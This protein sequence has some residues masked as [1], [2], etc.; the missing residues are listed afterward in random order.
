MVNNSRTFREAGKALGTQDSPK[1]SNMKG[2][3]KR[4]YRIFAAGV[5]ISGIM[6]A[7][8]SARAGEPKADGIKLTLSANAFGGKHDLQGVLAGGGLSLSGAAK[9]GF[10]GGAS[11]ELASTGLG[12]PVPYSYGAYALMPLAQNLTGSIHCKKDAFTGGLGF[13]G[14]LSMGKGPVLVGAGGEYRPGGTISMNASIGTK[15]KLAF[16]ALKAKI[17]GFINTKSGGISAGGALA[18]AELMTGYHVG[19]YGRYL[20]FTTGYGDSGGHAAVGGAVTRFSF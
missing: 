4:A 19:L 3:L 14:G 10:G 1:P 18:S 6:L 7:S 2:A 12:R 16:L 9:N 5:L 17:A 20:Y 11:F 13:G 15:L 8:A